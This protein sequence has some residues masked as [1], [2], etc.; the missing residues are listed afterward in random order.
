MNNN[1]LAKRLIDLGDKISDNK[2]KSDR[3]DAKVDTIKDKF[4][5]KGLATPK[6]V[7]DRIDELETNVAN[8]DGEIEKGL[9]ELEEKYDV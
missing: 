3:I 7:S 9:G 2:T 5:K 6:A 8:I 4:K 1:D